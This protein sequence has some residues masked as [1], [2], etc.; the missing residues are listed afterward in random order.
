MDFRFDT[1]YPL[2]PESFEVT[3]QTPEVLRAAWQ[4]HNAQEFAKGVG[5]Q[6]GAKKKEK[7]GIGTF[8]AI[9]A[10][11]LVIIVG[12]MWYKNSATMAKDMNKINNRINTI[13]SGVVA[14]TPI[15]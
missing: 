13:N 8:L 2:N 12:Y 5:S 3:W 10:I 15:K 11:A 4:E 1:P 9:V 14:T 7:F 6:G